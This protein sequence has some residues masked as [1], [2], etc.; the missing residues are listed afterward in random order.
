MQP[1]SE[2]GPLYKVD[3]GPGPAWERG[4]LLFEDGQLKQTDTGQVL[5][6]QLFLAASP[7]NSEVA[8]GAH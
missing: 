8:T 6:L 2:P 3:R 1:K 5:K 7:S 4:G